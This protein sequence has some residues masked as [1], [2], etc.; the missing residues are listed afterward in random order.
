MFEAI[1]DQGGV[2]NQ[3]VGDGLMAIFGAPLTQPDHC[4][5]CRQSLPGYDRYDPVVNADRLAQGKIQIRIGIGIASG[6]VIAGYTGHHPPGHLYLRRRHRQPGRPLESH[7][8]WSA[9]P[10]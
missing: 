8:K 1:S 6:Q 9:S 5:T 2:V 4:E 10:S 3:M 7:T